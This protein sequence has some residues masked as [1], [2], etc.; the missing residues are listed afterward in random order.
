MS[1]L[2]MMV[3]VNVTLFEDGDGVNIDVDGNVIGW[4]SPKGVL[5]L[6]RD[7]YFPGSQNDK[8]GHIKVVKEGM[9]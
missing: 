2:K 4:I 3:E 5:V 8:D 6:A 1:V 9:E 7:A